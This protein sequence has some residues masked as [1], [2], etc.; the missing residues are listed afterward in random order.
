MK[1]NKLFIDFSWNYVSFAILASSG[2]LINLLI[3][4]FYSSEGLGVFNQTYAIFVIFSQFSVFGIHYSVLKVSSET[5]P[6]SLESKQIL[7]SG[8]C[9]V[10]F[11]SSLV[12][13]IL[14]FLSSP[15]SILFDSPNI[16]KTL[17]IVAPALILIS[18]NKV[19]LSFLNG[20]ENLKQFAIGNIIRY[21]FM[22]ISLFALIAYQAKI[23]Q[24]AYIFLISELVV[25]T[26]SLFILK[27]FFQVYD[28]KKLVSMSVDHARF[29]FKALLSGLSVELNSRVDVVILGV[30]VG[31]SV[32]G[33][34]SFF[35]MFAEGMYNIFVVFK[36]IF[37][38]KITKFIRDQNL[39]GLRGLILYLQKIIYPLSFLIVIVISSIV[40]TIVFYL[41][42]SQI[43]LDNFLIL[44]ILLASIFFISGFIPFELILTLGGKPGL[45]SLQTTSTL[46][47]NIVLNILLV[48]IYFGL[49]ASFATGLSYIFG[50]ILLQVFSLRSIGIRII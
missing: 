15:I 38:P 49:G 42:D 14:Y 27:N 9:S 44:L 47:F 31:D 41:P 37:N 25:S 29:G 4:Y 34:Y 36:N 28:F 3:A 50:M 22:L 45:Q 1:L 46:F 30:F 40:Y 48:P 19:L 33:V 24:L 39:I 2:V 20:Q 10:L 35:S 16:Q 32:V 26:Y 5:K 17:I 21:V 12:A 43:Y 6:N 11:L 8:L 7:L 13:L 18:V 23:H